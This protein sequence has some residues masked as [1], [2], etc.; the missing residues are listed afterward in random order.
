MREPALIATF[1][2]LKEVSS[3]SFPGYYL[4][5]G[6]D[7]RWCAPVLWAS[8]VCNDNANHQCLH[9][10]QQHPAL[11]HRDLPVFGQ[12]PPR[13]RGQEYWSNWAQRLGY[14]FWQNSTERMK[15]LALRCVQWECLRCEWQVVRELHGWWDFILCIYYIYMSHF[16]GGFQSQV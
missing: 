4:P 11:G 1:T 16:N 10:H 12:Q 3:L 2:W 15:D 5:G 9:L 14:V 6:S 13:Q 7:F 8:G